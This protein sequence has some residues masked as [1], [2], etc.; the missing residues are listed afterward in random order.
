MIAFISFYLQEFEG[1]VIGWTRIFAEGSLK[2]NDRQCWQS[3]ARLLG[4]GSD[5]CGDLFY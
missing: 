4:E 5:F 1:A 2:R 3:F